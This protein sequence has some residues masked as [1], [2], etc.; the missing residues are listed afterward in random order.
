ML[1]HSRRNMKIRIINRVA[2]YADRVGDTLLANTCRSLKGEYLTQ[3]GRV[4]A[5]DYAFILE[6]FE[7]TADL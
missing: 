2:A 4:D 3:R 1:T 7:T 5:I 6:I